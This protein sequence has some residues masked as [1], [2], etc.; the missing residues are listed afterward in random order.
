M[1]AATALILSIAA[2]VLS[3]IALIKQYLS[4]GDRDN[5]DY[6]EL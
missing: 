5:R 3:T 6:H 4:D 1:L 2:L